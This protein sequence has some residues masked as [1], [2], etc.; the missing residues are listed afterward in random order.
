[1]NIIA[2]MKLSNLL[3]LPKVGRRWNQSQS[4]RLLPQSQSGFTLIEMIAVVIII[5]V[6]SAIIAPG[7]LAFVNRQRVAK[8]NDAVFSAIQEAQREA[9][10]TK[11]SY[12]VS[13]RKDNTTNAL[14]K[15]VYRTFA[16]NGTT[17]ITPTNNAWKSL[18]E[19]LDIKP[20]QV[21][22][23]SNL[24]SAF[25]KKGNSLDCGFTTPKTITFDYQGNLAEQASG[26]PA[27]TDLMVAVGIP[28][29]NN[30]N[31]V[32]DST[33]RCVSVKTLIGSMQVGQGDECQ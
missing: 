11:R 16:D 33:K 12:S 4:Q 14:Q 18:S 20:D 15:V 21:L 22:L 17:P 27:H 25:N 30:P 32:I 3:T 1:M 29:S 23:C 10:R 28:Q 8:M 13:F 31:Q 5:A 19:S 26:D 9:K 2:F 7:W 6:L 24:L